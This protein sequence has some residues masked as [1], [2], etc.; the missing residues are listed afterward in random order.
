MSHKIFISH[1]SS[2]LPF[3]EIALLYRNKNSAVLLENIDSKARGPLMKTK[4]VLVT[5][6]KGDDVVR[7][8]KVPVRIVKSL[9]SLYE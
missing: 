2:S 7:E 5:E 9:Q 1:E 4:E 8:Y 6:T 3:V